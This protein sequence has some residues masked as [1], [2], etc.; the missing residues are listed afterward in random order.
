MEHTNVFWRVWA[1]L[2]WASIVISP[3]VAAIEVKILLA[4]SLRLDCCWSLICLMR[5][6]LSQFSPQLAGT[7][8]AVRDCV[9]E[10][11]LVKWCSRS[12]WRH[13]RRV[14]TYPCSLKASTEKPT[15]GVDQYDEVGFKPMWVCSKLELHN[16][17]G[18][19]YAGPWH[20]I[21]SR[22]ATLRQ[23][24]MM[25]TFLVNPVEHPCCWG[26]TM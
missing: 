9:G 5:L 25:N 16:Y 11:I 14:D 15:D 10:T 20:L 12:A 26:S 3:L 22:K 8:V 19:S 4:T 7:A 18:A 17:F 6:Q 23:T 21:W 13:V 1:W 2:A 24:D